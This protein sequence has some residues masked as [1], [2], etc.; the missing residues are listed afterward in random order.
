MVRYLRSTLQAMPSF[1]IP[2]FLRP[3]YVYSAQNFRADCIAGITVAFIQIPQSM[4]F[5]IIAG[6]PAVYGLYAS[7]PGF[8]AS[9]WGSSRQLSTGP[10]AVISLLTFTSLVSF[11]EP[12]SPEFIGLAAL[13]ATLVGIMYVAVGVFRLGFVMH[14]VPQSVI[15]GFT[16]A[17]AAIIVATQLP[18]LFG[19]TVVRHELVLQDVF[20]FLVG[21]PNLVPLTLIVGGTAVGLLY[22]SRKLPN[23]FP[24]ALLILVLGI[25]AGYLFDL[26]TYGV[27]LVADIPASLPFFAFPSLSAVPFIS[28][29]PKA[30]IIALVGFVSAHATA[31]TAARKSKELFDTNR[32]LVGQGL[33]NIVTGFFRGYPISGSFTRTA[34]NIEAGARTGMA[35]VVAALVTVVALLFLTPFFYYLPKPVLAAIVIVAAIPLIDIR[36]LREMYRISR[37]DGYIA[38]L[39]FAMALIL[40]PDDALLIGTVFALML[41]IH[42]SAWGSRVFEMGVDKEWQ[43]LRG[44]IEEERVE[45]FP[46][47]CVA[48]I[49]TSL[50]YGNVTNLMQQMNELIEENSRREGKPVRILVFDVS[51]V[52]FIDITALDML[53]ENI[54]RLKKRGVHVCFLYLRRALREALGRLPN[55]S[56]V[57]IL[58]NINELRQ[59]SVSDRGHMLFLAGSHPE[60]LG[61]HI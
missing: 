10:V 25:M 57:T 6:L 26:D 24:G 52:H 30:A 46:G 33:A 20:G 59:L 13:L 51:A 32:E 54:E 4:A 58:H 11:A 5:A 36:R 18:A 39:T 17:A 14:L 45:T 55:L 37:N 7:L 16:S 3:G 19:V 12:G 43:V 31:K 40:R 61:T 28:L 9:L 22:I 48:H 1:F 8:I 35:S 27:A 29:L 2:T 47:I 38:Y 42:Q 23:I 50:Y 21:L 49:G 60:K 15:V 56:E 44:A 41:F 34:I 53:I